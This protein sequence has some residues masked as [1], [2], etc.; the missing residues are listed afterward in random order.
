MIKQVNIKTTIEEYKIDKS[1]DGKKA[2]YNLVVACYKNTG[3]L[4]P[5]VQGSLR[6]D[7]YCSN[8][9]KHYN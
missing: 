2:I 5:I 3:K 8:C 4:Y 9:Q 6:R 1:N 7:Y